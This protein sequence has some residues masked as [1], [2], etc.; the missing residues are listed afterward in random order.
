[1]KS[2]KEGILKAINSYPN[3]SILWHMWNGISRN[4]EGGRRAAPQRAILLHIPVM[5]FLAFGSTP[6]PVYRNLNSPSTC[7]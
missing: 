4:G 5:K 3:G 2:P 7:T 6:S 1:M